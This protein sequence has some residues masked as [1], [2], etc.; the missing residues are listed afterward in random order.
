MSLMVSILFYLWTKIYD[1][2]SSHSD[3]TVGCISKKMGFNSWQMH[4]FFS[5]PQHPIQ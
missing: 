3:Y 2:L 5:S 1:L 4:K